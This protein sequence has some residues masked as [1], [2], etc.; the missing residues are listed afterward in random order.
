[1]T[2]R[3]HPRDDDSTEHPA[4]KRRAVAGPDDSP[5]PV[6]V[7]VQPADD[8]PLPAPDVKEL[9]RQIASLENSL[10]VRDVIIDELKTRLSDVHYDFRRIQDDFRK[11]DLICAYCRSW[12]SD[13]TCCGAC[14]YEDECICVLCDGCEKATK[15]CECKL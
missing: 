9:E 10:C 11:K 12:T 2:E 4:A 8:S 6:S 15:Y 1:M 5:V 13:C 3:K 14:G 7:P